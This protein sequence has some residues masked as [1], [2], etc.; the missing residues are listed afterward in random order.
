MPKSLLDPHSC[1]LLLRA[2]QGYSQ[3]ML[4]LYL[5]NESKRPA[6]PPLLSLRG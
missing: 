1:E 6:A 3:R 4:L 5:K 2:R